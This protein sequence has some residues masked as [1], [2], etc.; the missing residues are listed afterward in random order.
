MNITL[1]ADE[2]KTIIA[3]Y[4]SIPQEDIRVGTIEIKKNMRV[5]HEPM[6]VIKNCDMSGIDIAKN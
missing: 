6:A 3:I 5:D 4:F 2:I 1:N